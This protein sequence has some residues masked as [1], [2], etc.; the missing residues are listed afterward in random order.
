V[1]NL[2]DNYLGN[3]YEAKLRPSEGYTAFREAKFA[4]NY[5]ARLAPH[6]GGSLLEIGPGMGEF[7]QFATEHASFAQVQGVDY[8]PDCVA[9]CRSAGLDVAHIDALEPWL[10]DHPAEFSTIVMLHVLEH[11]TKDDV[12]DTL[13][14]IRAALRPG[15]ILIA[16]VPNAGNPWLSGVARYEDFTHQ[17]GYTSGSLRFVMTMA[18]FS[19]VTIAGVKVPWKGKY[20]PVRAASEVGNGFTKVMTKLVAPRADH[21]LDAQIYAVATA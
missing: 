7:L 16:E 8:A 21:L 12:F 9:H 13:H 17:V 18:G 15:G 19:Q 5:A 2:Y 1:D 20:L 11:I 4:H 14:A 10:A 3:Y 6:R